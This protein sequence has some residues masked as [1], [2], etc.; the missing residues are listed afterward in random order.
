M[1]K[2][3]KIKDC[4]KPVSSKGLC[5]KHYNLDYYR[6]HNKRIC[7]AIDCEKP[8]YLSFKFCKK[9]NKEYKDCL[10]K[11]TLNYYSDY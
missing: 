11:A 3:C 4:I 5:I 8:A 10:N 9:H 1:K 6:K 2:E 7:K